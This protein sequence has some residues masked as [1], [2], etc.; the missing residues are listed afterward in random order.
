MAV[1]RRWVFASADMGLAQELAEALSI[2]VPV[3][4]A[5]LGRGVSDPLSA[6][7]F[8]NPRLRDLHDPL[9]MRD[10]D[11]AVFRTVAAMKAG[12]RIAVHGDYDADGIT[13]T[14][15]LASFFEAVGYPVRTCLPERLR[16]GY[17]LSKDRIAALAAEGVRLLIAVDC[18]VS[19]VAEVAFARSLGVDTVVLDHHQPGPSLPDAAAVVDPHREDCDFPF[20]DLSAAG[21]AFYFAGALRRALVREGRIRD[22]EVDLKPLLDFAAIGTI[23][24]VVPLLS[25]NRVIVAAGLRR[26]NEEPRVGIVALRAVAKVAPGK[27][28]TSGTVAFTLAPRLNATGRMGDAAASLSLLLSRDP[29]EAKRH[30]ETLDREN[31]NRRLVEAQ[32]LAAALKQ[33]EDAGGPQGRIV[34]VAGEGW[35]P[36]VVGIVASR[37]VERYFRPAVVLGIEDGI[38]KGSCR[39]VKGFDIGHALKRLRHILLK[40]GG[41]AMAAG[42]TLEAGRIGEFVEAVRSLA[43]KEVPDLALVPSILVDAVVQPKDVSDALLRSLI[44]LQPFGVGNPEPVFA[45][46]A[47]QVKSSRRVGQNGEH[48]QMTIGDPP[49]RA[50]WFNALQCPDVGAIVD[51]AFTVSVDDL[52]GE[53]RL[54]VRD[55]R[56]AGGDGA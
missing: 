52:S 16:E 56:P 48:C 49:L 8:L 14:A 1:A 38:A 42:L 4:A 36:G 15:L 28:M 46:V 39:S 6:Q 43:E 9:A 24:D 40:H 2:P 12:Q 47:A 35:H 23:A 54:K 25:D 31:Q 11:L 13:A 41:H 17:G 20:K 3:A 50:V 29:E 44:Y 45:L 30:A 55:V 27:P 18:G 26:L 53:P 10:M 21:I 19:N 37:L 34:V 32:V 7:A 22:G 5:L 33:V 51:V